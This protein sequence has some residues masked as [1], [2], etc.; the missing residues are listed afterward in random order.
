MIVIENFKSIF[1]CLLLLLLLL[2]YNK[3]ENEFEA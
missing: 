3:Q 1:P 2:I